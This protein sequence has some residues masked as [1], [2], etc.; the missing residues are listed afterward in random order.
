MIKKLFTFL[1]ICL[2]SLLL[3]GCI[4]MKIA[5][6][7]TLNEDM[8]IDRTFQI[9][10]SNNMYGFADQINSALYE[11]LSES[12]YSNI[13]NAYDS[14]YFGK[15]GTRH[16]DADLGMAGAISNKYVRV[17]DN[18]QDFFIFKHVDITAYIDF[19]NILNNNQNSDMVTLTEYKL[20]LNLPIAFSETNAQNVYNNGKSA[21]WRFAPSSGS[22]TVH[23]ECNVPNK[24]NIQFLLICVA[25]I[26][27]FILFVKIL[28]FAYSISQASSGPKCPNCGVKININTTFCGNCGHQLYQEPNSVTDENSAKCPQC[29]AALKEDSLFCGNCGYQLPQASENELQQEYEKGEKV[30]MEKTVHANDSDDNVKKCPKC[31]AILK[32]DDMFCGE[33]GYKLNQETTEDNNEV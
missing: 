4:N 20:T 13:V 25:G 1:S 22:G 16:I 15:K 7:Y 12:G 31:S 24:D 26:F 19:N 28:S 10:V 30:E 3:T 18:S 27:G 14:D 2:C 9:L 17:E 23:F 11:N 8:S 21:T 29:G 32:D 6:E 33:C 5:D